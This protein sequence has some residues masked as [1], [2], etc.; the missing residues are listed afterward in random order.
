MLVGG[1]APLVFFD[2]IL[3]VF[4]GGMCIAQ[5]L[6]VMPDDV[7]V[8]YEKVRLCTPYEWVLL[9]VLVGCELQM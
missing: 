4:N 6:L 5:V 8:L 1:S 7:L 9:R 3:G 2:D